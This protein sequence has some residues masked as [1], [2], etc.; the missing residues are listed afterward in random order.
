MGKV[1]AELHERQASLSPASW[2]TQ[3]ACATS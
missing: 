1:Y 3:V 2:V